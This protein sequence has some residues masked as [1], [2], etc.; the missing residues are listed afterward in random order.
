MPMNVEH[1]RRDVKS[2]PDNPRWEQVEHEWDYDLLLLASVLVEEDGGAERGF[3]SGY[4][5]LTAR[6]EVDHSF[7]TD[8]P[9]RLGVK[10][11]DRIRFWR[12]R[13]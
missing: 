6:K 4:G 11:G 7:V 8:Y 12:S 9:G 10:K 1:L 13:R 2:H 5:V 3:G